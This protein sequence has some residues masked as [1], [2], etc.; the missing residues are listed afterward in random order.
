MVVERS[1]PS[2]L[3]ALSVP[4]LAS[5]ALAGTPAEWR[6]R[7]IYQVL[8]D[9]FANTASTAP[10]DNLQDYCGGSW[11]GLEGKL[12]YIA[13]LGFDAIWISP[14]VENT[15][16]GYHGY[17][18]KNLSNVNAYFGSEED[19]K[20]LV[21]AAHAKGIWVMVDVVGNHMGGQIGDVGGYAPFNQPDHYHDCQGC[22]GNCDITDF[23]TLYSEN[24]EHCRLSG[25]PDLDQDNGYVKQQL[26]A[27]VGS[28]VKEFN[29]DGVRVD[30][31]PEVKPA[32]WKSF[33]EAAGTFAIGEVFNGD[34]DYVSPFQGAALDGVLSYPMYFQLR[35]VYASQ[36]SF[37]ELQTLSDAMPNKFSDT[38]IIGSFVGNHDNPRFLNQRNDHVA[39]RN[40]LLNMLFNPGIPIVYYGSE[41]GFSGGNDPQCREVMW[42]SGFDTSNDL[43]TF[44]KSAIAARKSTKAWSLSYPKY[45]HADD[46]IGVF[47]RGSELLVA[48]TNVGSSGGD[49][50]QTVSVSGIVGDGTQF[51][52]ALGSGAC[53]TVNGGLINLKF[54][55]GEPQLLVK[56]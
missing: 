14:V 46:K 30:T 44:L 40:A 47:S 55:G 27:W 21:Q 32:F 45:L 5:V 50:S 2:L 16:G 36:Q 34:V 17:W 56:Q 19:L 20:S 10:C 41:Q 37:T 15:P 9:R 49:L 35:N 33:N 43:Y 42:T 39:Y 12:D 23:N 22:D 53:V 29:F 54:T 38:S 26:N 24:C 31:V 48:T 28:L 11:K 51:C 8:T 13:D 18:A 6:D 4:L 3:S 25:L 7:T 52:D 1:A